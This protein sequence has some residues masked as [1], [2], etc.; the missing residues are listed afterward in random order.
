[1]SEYDAAGRQAAQAMGQGYA[2]APA[3]PGQPGAAPGYAAG[4]GQ[5]PPQMA[6]PMPPQMP[7][8]MPPWPMPPPYGAPPPGPWPAPPPAMPPAGA[9]PPPWAAPYGWPPMP[10]YPPA[11]GPMAGPPPG[12][13]PGWGQVMEEIASGGLSGLGKLFDLDDKDFWKGAALGAAAVL[14]LTNESVQRTL[15]RGAV[16]GRDAVQ[17]GVDQ[18]K[19]GADRLKQAVRESHEK[20]D[21]QRDA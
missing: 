11:P 18:V 15:F 2:A 8:Q 6:P 7:P 10:G 19:S 14:L 5:A 17:S 16:R 1:M 21:E 9:Y 13:R 20:P 3:G 12:P 4:P